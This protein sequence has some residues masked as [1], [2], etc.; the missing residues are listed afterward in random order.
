MLRERRERWVVPSQQPSGHPVP[1]ETQRRS[2][3][4]EGGADGAPYGYGAVV[5]GTGAKV[6]DCRRIGAV[7]KRMDKKDF[8]ED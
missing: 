3:T 8:K 7:A 4:G 1:T 5:E 2:P 6:W